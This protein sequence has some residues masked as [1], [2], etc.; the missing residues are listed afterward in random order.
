[1]LKKLSKQLNGEDWTWNN[2]NTLCWAIGSISGSMAEEQVPLFLFLLWFYHKAKYWYCICLIIGNSWIKSSFWIYILKWSLL[3]FSN[4][5][6]MLPCL[7]SALIWLY[8]FDVPPEI[9]ISFCWISIYRLIFRVSVY[10]PLL[11][12]K[13]WESLDQVSGSIFFYCSS[14]S[15]F[16]ILVFILLLD[17]GCIYDITFSTIYAFGRKIDF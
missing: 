3:Y 12:I 16:Y 5:T 15:H 6:K 14:F 10:I 7:C 11:Y 1:M 4:E 2:L 9:Y 13:F 8:L 17:S